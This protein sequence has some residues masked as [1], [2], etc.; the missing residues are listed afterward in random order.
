[1]FNAR[2]NRP[3]GRSLIACSI[4]SLR[5]RV[6]FHSLFRLLF[7]FR[8]HYLFTIDL[9]IVFRL[10]SGIRDVFEQESQL[11]RLHRRSYF[12][13]GILLGEQHILTRSTCHKHAD[14][15]V[16][17][18]GAVFQTDLAPPTIHDTPSLASSKLHIGW[19]KNWDAMARSTFGMVLSLLHSPLLKGS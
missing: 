16:T 19:Q 6:L 5:F 7:I 4:P 17:L 18:H 12:S 14:G 8:S 15:A 2:K 13:T 11:A 1:M 3:E 10:I 9:H